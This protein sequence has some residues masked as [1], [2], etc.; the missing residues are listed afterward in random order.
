M[1][2]TYRCPG[3]GEPGGR[4]RRVHADGC[5]AQ[6]LLMSD[7]RRAKVGVRRGYAPRPELPKPPVPPDLTVRQLAKLIEKMQVRATMFPDEE[8]PGASV[9]V[10]YG[11]S[12]TEAEVLA[13][14]DLGR[15]YN[16]VLGMR[17]VPTDPE[18]GPE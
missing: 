17:R 5:C 15:E 14:Y 12:H 18:E 2:I 4:G 7:E 16:L 11:P 13:L 8:P 10:A 1:A 6:F 9:S 3:I